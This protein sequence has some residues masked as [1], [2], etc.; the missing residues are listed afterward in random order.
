MVEP[1]DAQNML[2]RTPLVEKTVAAQQENAGQLQAQAA[3]FKKDRL[4]EGEQVKREKEADRTEDSTQKEGRTPRETA[5]HQAQGNDREQN[6]EWVE[7]RA[8]EPEHHLDIT[9]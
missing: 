3:Q 6:V 4:H 1:L 9:I 5:Q 2:S 8:D 7:E